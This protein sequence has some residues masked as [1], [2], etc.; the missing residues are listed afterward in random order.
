MLAMRA[1]AAGG[2]LD[3]Q[4][5]ERWPNYIAGNGLGTSLPGFD[6]NPEEEDILGPNSDNVIYKPEEEEPESTTP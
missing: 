5:Q 2:S 3:A 4:R 6:D 1:M